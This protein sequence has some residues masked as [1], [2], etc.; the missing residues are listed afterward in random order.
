MRILIDADAF[1]ALYNNRDVLN[2]RTEEIFK[3]LENKR[4][5]YFTTCDVIDEVTTKLS[6]FLTK[7]ASTT[8]PREIVES[9]TE[10]IYPT[11]KSFKKTINKIKSI[12]SKRVSFT[13]C[14]N[15]VAYGKYAIDAIFSFDKVYEKQGLKTLR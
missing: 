2:K 15:M 9:G 6:Y 3:K 4:A 7:K 13:D 12:R 8:F 1:I 11:E 5:K 14:A 10:I